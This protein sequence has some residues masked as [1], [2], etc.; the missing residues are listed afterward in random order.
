MFDVVIKFPRTMSLNDYQTKIDTLKAW[1]CDLELDPALTRPIVELEQERVSASVVEKT[2]D[3]FT[4]MAETLTAAE[5]KLI[6]RGLELI[7]KSE[8]SP[9][10]D[11]LAAA[12]VGKLK[13]NMTQEIIAY[14]KANP[15]HTYKQCATFMA[16][17]FVNHYGTRE[18]GYRKLTALLH[19]LTYTPSQ[20]VLRSV[21]GTRGPHKGGNIYVIGEGNATDNR[22]AQV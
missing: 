13:P 14:Y 1:G 17:K 9:L 22:S 4:P 3:P 7:H 12:G 8:T 20:K 5:R 18:I 11:Q 21:G 6:D 15:G 16:D 2:A 10:I 19:T